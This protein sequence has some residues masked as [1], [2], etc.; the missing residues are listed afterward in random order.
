[1][2]SKK[3]Y[4]IIRY[5]AN[6]SY[7]KFDRKFHAV[8]TDNFFLAKEFCHAADQHETLFTKNMSSLSVSCEEEL[9]LWN[10]SLDLELDKLYVYVAKL[11]PD[12]QVITSARLFDD[13]YIDWTQR[14]ILSHFSFDVFLQNIIQPFLVSSQIKLQLMTNIRSLSEMLN[15][16]KVCGLPSDNTWAFQKCLICNKLDEV[17]LFYHFDRGL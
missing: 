10:S 12:E 13:Y 14:S 17:S 8:Y 4:Y 5:I 1:M 3:K 11:N 16:N 6:E 2:G 7:C 15:G 9:T